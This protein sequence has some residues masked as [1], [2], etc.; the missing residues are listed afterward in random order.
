API[1]GRGDRSVDPAGSV[2]DDS[3]GPGGGERSLAGP[4]AGVVRRGVRLV[5]ITNRVRPG[6]SG[7][8]SRDGCAIPAPGGGEPVARGTA[9][10]RLRPGAG[11]TE[12]VR[13]RG[14]RADAIPGPGP[15]V[16]GPGRYRWRGVGGWDS[17]AGGA[18]VDRLALRGAHGRVPGRD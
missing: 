1:R 11:R 6:V 12:V 15:V 9:R 18:T 5:G 8:R 17:P 2:R 7:G 14:D 4:P 13:R 10:E 16:A 3:T